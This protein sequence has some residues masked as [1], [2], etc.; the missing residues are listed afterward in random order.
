LPR[1]RVQLDFATPKAQ[2]TQDLKTRGTP[3]A[4]SA[5]ENDDAAT[6]ANFQSST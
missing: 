3:A 5:S 2:R 4:W 1:T 6:S